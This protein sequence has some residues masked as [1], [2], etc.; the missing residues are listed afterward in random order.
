ME[1][2]GKDQDFI[3]TWTEIEDLKNKD[4]IK[5][6]VGHIHSYF[7]DSQG[8]IWVCGGN[9]RGQLCLGHFESPI[10]S[11]TSVEFFIKQNVK[12]REIECGRDFVIMIDY[13]GNVWG[14]GD[15]QYKQ[16]GL[17]D[18]D[19]EDKNPYVATPCKVKA[20]DNLNVEVIKCGKYHAFMRCEGNKNYMWGDNSS[21]QCVIFDDG[22]DEK[23]YVTQP[24][25]IE[26]KGE[27]EVIDV[28]LG[29]DNTKIIFDAS[30]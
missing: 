26:L 22:F 7:L 4:I 2:M 12:I 15:N 24:T 6:R 25:L 1:R 23:D 11:I 13:D 21:N 27:H 16:L 3:E 10:S 5:I 28:F 8:I 30:K 19:G 17:G 29:N 9:G 20:S 18:G 14:C